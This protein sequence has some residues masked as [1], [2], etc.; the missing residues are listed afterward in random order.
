[1]RLQHFQCPLQPC[2]IVSD[3]LNLFPPMFTYLV[4]SRNETKKM[5]LV[6]LCVTN[7]EVFI[8][9]SANIYW[10]LRNKAKVKHVLKPLIPTS[11]C[12]TAR[13]KTV[14]ITSCIICF[15]RY[16]KPCYSQNTN[17]ASESMTTFL[18][19]LCSVVS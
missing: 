8:S 9:R 2:L 14:W 10:V 1:M 6:W 5:M 16:Q 11:L 17:H 4:L 15:I 7:Y 12:R 19:I 18:Q 3:V 13:N